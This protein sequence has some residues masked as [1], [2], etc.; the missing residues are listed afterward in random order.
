MPGA[1]PIVGGLAGSIFGSREKSKAA[2]RATDAQVRATELGIAESGRRFDEVQKLLAPFVGAGESA[3]GGLLNLTGLGDPEA[4]R[5]AII[6]IEGSPEFEARTRLGEEAILQNASA[7]GG[8]RGGN[9]Q[10]ALA[11]FRPQVLSDLIN[12]Q[13]GRLSGISQLG[14]A[15]AAGVGSAGLQTGQNISDLLLEQGQARGQGALAQGQTKSALFGDVAGAFGEILPQFK[16]MGGE[17]IF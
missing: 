11:Q 2:D 1:L 14:Q 7:T 10:A 8:L 9:I 13:F 4:A 16:F 12:K 15:S 3:I 17:G 5:N 6:D